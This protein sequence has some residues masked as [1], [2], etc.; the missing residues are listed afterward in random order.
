MK[1]KWGW[2]KP[3]SAVRLAKRGRPLI[4]Q[5]GKRP[6]Q[7][8]GLPPPAAETPVSPFPPVTKGVKTSI[9]T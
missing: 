9:T 4:G 5:G 3:L 8:L 2:N 7:K 1:I 6:T